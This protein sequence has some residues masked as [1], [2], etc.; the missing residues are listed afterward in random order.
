MVDRSRSSATVRHPR[1]APKYA[2][3][4]GQFEDRGAGEL[5]DEA[6]ARLVGTHWKHLRG[7]RGDGHGR[8]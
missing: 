3:L 2:R 7:G 4:A 5:R 8:W 1:F 6:L